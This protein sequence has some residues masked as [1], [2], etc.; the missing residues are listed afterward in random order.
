M[1]L[2][3]ALE[4]QNLAQREKGWYFSVSFL[5]HVPDL[6][7]VVCCHTLQDWWLVPDDALLG[8]LEL[9]FMVKTRRSTY[10]K[11]RWQKEH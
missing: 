7:S 5:S 11:G 9:D 3:L 6:V 1:I 10:K 4:Y 8:S 2:E